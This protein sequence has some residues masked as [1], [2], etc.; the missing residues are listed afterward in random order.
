M[1]PAAFSTS[2]TPPSPTLWD[3]DL[4]N[5]RSRIG[6]LD[7]CLTRR[8]KG[9]NCVGYELLTDADLSHLAGIEKLGVGRCSFITVSTFLSLV[10]IK[11]LTVYDCCRLVDD[12][13]LCLTAGEGMYCEVV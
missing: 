7:I 9:V 3:V 4:Y 10:G 2:P 1:H 8:Y 6:L 5:C 13:A 11:E 12:A